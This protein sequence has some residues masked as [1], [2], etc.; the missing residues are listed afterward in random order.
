MLIFSNDTLITKL[1]MEVRTVWL[2]DLQLYCPQLYKMYFYCNCEFVLYK[3]I[4]YIYV[5]DYK[6]T[7]VIFLY[8]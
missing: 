5:Y 2:A 4:L 7:Q 1:R 3:Y 6:K 8:V